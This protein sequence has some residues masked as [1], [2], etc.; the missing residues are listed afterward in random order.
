MNTLLAAIIDD[1]VA[2]VT[3]LLRINPSLASQFV[4]NERLYRAGIFHW[5][6][7]GDT[8]LHLAVAWYRVE[9]VRELLAAGADPNS[10]GN[11]RRSTPLHYASDG[12]ITGPAWN[13]EIQVTTLRT[14][15][16]AGSDVNYIDGYYNRIRL[17]SG[18]GYRSPIEFERQ[19]TN[20]TSLPQPD[21]QPVKQRRAMPA[22]NPSRNN[23]PQT[24]QP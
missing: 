4:E 14:L 20:G 10:A 23:R 22:G 12:Y 2:R 5:L 9:I 13:P 16:T 11:R 1:D 17:H 19:L 6:Y 21:N 18:L 7:V 8:A 3:E 24:H 15:V